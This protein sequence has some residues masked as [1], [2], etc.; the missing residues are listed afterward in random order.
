MKIVDVQADALVCKLEKPFWS[1]RKS[2]P[3][4]EG[5]HPH[6]SR[7]MVLVRVLTDEGL[8][9]VGEAGLAGSSPLVV[10]AAVKHQAK[11]AVMGED[12]LR[13]ERLVARI[14]ENSFPSSRRG[15]ANLA[16]S[17]VEMA[18]WDLAGKYYGAPVHR[19]LGGFRQAVPAYA[20]AGFYVE[21]EGETEL[22]AQA[23]R[24]L[25][26]GFRAM[27]MKIG[28]LTLEQDARRVEA[29]RDALGAEADLMVDVNSCYS[30]RQ[31]IAMAERLQDVNLTWMEEPV[32]VDNLDGAELVARSVGVPI[33]GY[34]TV[35]A[36]APFR[37]LISRG[38]I[39]Y[40]QPDLAWAGGFSGGRR[41]AALAEAWG[42]TICPHCF[43]SAVNIT[44]GMQ[45]IGGVSNARWLEY[46]RMSPNPLRDELL[47]EPLPLPVDGLVK[48]ND[49][50]GLGI[51]L[52]E[53]T[54][55]RYR[56]SDN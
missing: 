6:L 42:M 9:G 54:V 20:S 3:V 1:G 27:K 55:A 12:P 37:E 28:A 53:D 50:P 21:G 29:V 41:I 23:K 15:T 35:N 13:I 56:V 38:I 17:G 26:E 51:E 36:L 5:G 10:A 19:L 14:Y 43:S 18:L 34:E 25:Q 7:G 24:Y 47:T 46:D 44:A 33:A 31:A 45:F 32:K 52:N 48:L 30:P 11:P 4:S 40:P 39:D 8:T 2:V 16:L 49:R 22:V